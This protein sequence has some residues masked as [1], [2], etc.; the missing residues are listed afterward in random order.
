MTSWILA[1]LLAAKRAGTT[2]TGGSVT[3]TTLT[4]AGQA[5]TIPT[6]NVA[7]LA[8]TQDGTGSR[9]VTWPS[10]I[11][12]EGGTPPTLST[13]AG[14]T[15]VFT[16]VLL[17]GGGWLGKKDGSHPAP[18]DTT[19]PSAV[20]NLSASATD[21]TIPLSWTAATDNNAVTGYE[22][23]LNG[24]TW[25]STGSTGTTYTVT[26][27]TASTSYTVQVRA[28][29]AAGNKGAAASVTI[30][31]AAGALT[32]VFLD[33]FTRADGTIAAS[34]VVADTGQ[35]WAGSTA[36]HYI[37]SNKL[38]PRNTSATSC[39]YANHGAT[40]PVEASAKIT[41]GTTAQ[42]VLAFRASAAQTSTNMGGVVQI[43]SGGLVS[44][45]GGDA[46]LVPTVT[47]NIGGGTNNYASIQGGVVAGNEYPVKVTWSGN[48]MTIYVNNVRHL[49]GTLTSAQQT[50]LSGLT[51]VAVFGGAE[52]GFRVDD[53]K[54]S[55]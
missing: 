3:F 26:G 39:I 38:D 50:T 35:S 11:R 45:G 5:I 36:N 44:M 54:V 30:T 32:Q 47:Y 24:T 18:A 25:T 4:S 37:A 29:D 12:W 41:V 9:T 27:L 16:F 10:G 28:F 40:A 52:T 21:T 42:A 53:I 14:A 13:A 23:S 31:T 20:T 55:V 51:R 33:T 1:S 6:G 48:L 49:E 8:L 7:G 43:T 22:Y 2:G 46:T 17:S 15:D 34:G 19:A